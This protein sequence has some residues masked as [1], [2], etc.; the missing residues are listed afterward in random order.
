MLPIS[1]FQQ[2]SIISHFATIYR[3]IQISFKCQT[4]VKILFVLQVMDG[5]GVDLV[6]LSKLSMFMNVY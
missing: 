6:R 1:F 4:F 3:L 2:L 5:V